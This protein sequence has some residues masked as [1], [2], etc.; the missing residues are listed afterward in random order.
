MLGLGE[1]IEVY[2]L[3]TQEISAVIRTLILCSA[4]KLPCLLKTSG[5]KCNHGCGVGR[6]KVLIIGNLTKQCKAFPKTQRTQTT[7]RLPS[8]FCLQDVPSGQSQHGALS[9]WGWDLIFAVAMYKMISRTWQQ[10]TPEPARSFSIALMVLWCF[11]QLWLK[12]HSEPPGRF[13][14]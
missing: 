5:L 4:W 10:F 13:H 12:L 6:L 9:R 14:T 1:P 2:H 3:E 8:D 7:R 11:E